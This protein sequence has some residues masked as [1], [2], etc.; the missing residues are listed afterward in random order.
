[1]RR[2]RSHEEI[3][4]TKYE[5]FVKD[6]KINETRHK[7]TLLPTSINDTTDVSVFTEEEALTDLIENGKFNK[8]Q[9]KKI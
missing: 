5:R 1:L 4:Q 8:R 6:L 9:A 2:I 3:G 7:I